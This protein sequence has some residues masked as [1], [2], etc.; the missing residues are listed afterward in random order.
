MKTL[1]RETAH[2]QALCL[3]RHLFEAGVSIRQTSSKTHTSKSELSKP[4]TSNSEVLIDADLS[5]SDGSK[6]DTYE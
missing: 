1:L 6:A 2:K 4:D 5:Q 3:G